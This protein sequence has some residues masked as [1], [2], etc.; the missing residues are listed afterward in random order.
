M[1]NITN[2]SI[3]GTSLIQLFTP[4]GALIGTFPSMSAAIIVE[5]A[6]NHYRDNSGGSVVESD[7]ELVRPQAAAN[8]DQIEP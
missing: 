5:L 4:N 6:L 7:F 8:G 3:V 2:K 1:Q